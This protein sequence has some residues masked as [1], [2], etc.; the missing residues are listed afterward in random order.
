MNRPLSRTLVIAACLL[1]TLAATASAQV[2]LRYK[3]R[4]GQQLKYRT[5]QSI[6]LQTQISGKQIEVA[7]DQTIESTQQVTELTQDG[8]A[9]IEQTIDRVSMTI[10]RP[11]GT[12]ITFDSAAEGEPSAGAKPLAAV[13][14]ALKAAKFEFQ[15]SPRGEITAVA[16]PSD[17]HANL[18]QDP[19]TADFAKLFD[20]EMFKRLL[21]QGAP[22]F[23]EDPLVPQGQAGGESSWR[24]TFIVDNPNFGKQALQVI[25]TYLG[26]SKT[27]QGD[28]VHSVAFRMRTA[29]RPAAGSTT[30]IAVNQQQ[31]TGKMLFNN[32]LGRLHSSQL[33]QS[34]EL[35]VTSGEV[36]QTHKVDTEMSMELL[37]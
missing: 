22:T 19:A 4:Q 9:K 29:F 37:P 7:F 2:Q 30:T 23:P 25:Y 10:T 12:E 14:E 20:A 28:T 13:A 6:K 1:F 11:A 31:T 17:L 33:S 3:F 36:K 21:V 26:E 24:K 34:L 8:G 16:L 32:L 5:Q 18:S 15:M 35:Q 27:E